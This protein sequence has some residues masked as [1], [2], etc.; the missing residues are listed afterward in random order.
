MSKHA[1]VVRVDGHT[2]RIRTP[3]G[4][5]ITVDHPGAAVGDLFD[6]TELTLLPRRSELARRD[7]SGTRQVLAANVELVVIV[8]PL[9]R[10]VTPNRLDRE[11]V[12]AWDSGAQPLVVLTKSDLG[13]PPHDLGT[14]GVEVFAVDA[15]H[16]DLHDLAARL[17]L[18]A[19]VF[20]RR[21]VTA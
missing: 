12:L 10:P 17:T 16:G 18:A 1:L 6:Q 7:P 3:D 14:L 19:L 21:D 4:E 15:R 20:R 11:L 2:C 13:S 5:E 9:G 8:E